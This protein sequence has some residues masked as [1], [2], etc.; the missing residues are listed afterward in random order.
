VP[1]CDTMTVAITFKELALEHYFFDIFFLLRAFSFFL[2]VSA[3][4]S[5][6]V[7]FLVCG[8]DVLVLDAVI[9]SS[10]VPKLR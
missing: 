6:A 4:V 8:V 3:L 10:L 7:K 1:E 2:S 9:C 5:T